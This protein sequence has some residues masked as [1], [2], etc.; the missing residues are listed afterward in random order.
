MLTVE[1]NPSHSQHQPSARFP[2]E[3]MLV[4]DHTTGSE[5]QLLFF[6]ERF[7]PKD[8]PNLPKMRRFSAKLRQLGL[9]EETIGYGSSKEKWDKW[10]S[11]AGQTP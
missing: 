3:G 8:D 10:K 5:H 9:R 11:R 6:K 7:L 1:T 4:I 2:R